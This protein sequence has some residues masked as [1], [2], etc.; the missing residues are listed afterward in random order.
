MENEVS[1]VRP[2]KVHER[3]HLRVRDHWISAQVDA[4]RG[5]NSTVLWR[6]AAAERDFDHIQELTVDCR[7]LLAAVGLKVVLGEHFEV[8]L[9]LLEFV[10]FP[11]VVLDKPFL[12]RSLRGDDRRR[13]IVLERRVKRI[14]LDGASWRPPAARC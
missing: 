11:G 9:M 2:A 12:D 5:I 3:L 6:R 8:Y 7:R 10:V 14:R 4:S 1:N 13:I